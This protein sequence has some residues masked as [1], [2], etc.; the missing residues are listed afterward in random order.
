[1]TDL[2]NKEFID[3]LPY[4]FFEKDNSRLLRWMDMRMTP[5]KLSWQQ[6]DYLYSNRIVIKNI[7]RWRQPFSRKCYNIVKTVN[8]TCIVFV[9]NDV[10]RSFFITHGHIRWANE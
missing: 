5:G 4:D 2:L 6:L 8:D 7:G 10:P 9:E 1:M 3:I